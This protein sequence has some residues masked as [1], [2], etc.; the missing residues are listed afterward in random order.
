MKAVCPKNKT[1]K[2]F[3]TVAHVTQDWKVDERGNW[4]ETIHQ[5]IETTHGPNPGNTWTC[6]ECGEEAIIEES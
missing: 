6:V 4:L 1:H 5:G 3:I 2:E